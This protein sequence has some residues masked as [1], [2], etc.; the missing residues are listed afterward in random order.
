VKKNATA[1]EGLIQCV[2]KQVI[3][4]AYRSVGGASVLRFHGQVNLKHQA[5]S[6]GQ[7]QV[8]V[9][10]LAKVQPTLTKDN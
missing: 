9:A 10:R 1:A 2:N 5:E 6:L 7:E 4:I 3:F 8:A